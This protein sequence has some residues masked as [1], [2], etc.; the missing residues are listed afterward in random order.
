MKEV[1][2]KKLYKGKYVS[3]KDYHVRDAIKKNQHLK[4]NFKLESMVLSPSQL[5]KGILNPTI[6]FSAFNSQTYLSH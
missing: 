3:V 5:P 6:F 1:F 4:I 2:A